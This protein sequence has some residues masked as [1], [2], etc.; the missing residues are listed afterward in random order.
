MVVVAI[1]IVFAITVIVI[2]IAIVIDIAIAIVMVIV[3]V[4]VVDPSESPVCLGP[5]RGHIYVKGGAC[6]RWGG[7]EI[8][9]GCQWVGGTSV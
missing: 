6:E 5:D 2:A 4:I 1:V 8:E 7:R 3:V 9:G